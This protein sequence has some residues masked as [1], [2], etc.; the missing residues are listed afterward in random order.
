MIILTGDVH[1]QTMGGWEQEKIGSEILA[2][3]KYLE[4][5]KKNQI[6]ATLF[7]NGICLHNPGEKMKMRELLTYD[8]EL[9]GH[10]YN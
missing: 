6:K 7:I 9:G 8:V 1:S 10:T 2:S 4:I 5:L 3:K